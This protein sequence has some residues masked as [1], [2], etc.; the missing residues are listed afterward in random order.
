M[1][2]VY[3]F[4]AFETSYV[5]LGITHDNIMLW[6]TKLKLIHAFKND[7]SVCFSLKLRGTTYIVNSRYIYIAY[8]TVLLL[9]K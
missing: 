5:Y 1:Y 9:S 6:E 8:T 7:N 3:I 4:L 2:F